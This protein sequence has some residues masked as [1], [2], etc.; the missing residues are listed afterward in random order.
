M[1]RV[2]RLTRP[3]PLQAHVRV[4]GERN[5]ERADRRAGSAAVARWAD[6]WLLERALRRNEA[7]IA[8]SRSS[9][10]LQVQYRGTRKRTTL[11]PYRGPMPRALWWS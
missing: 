8:A 3:F 11:G 9:H 6:A 7:A 10:V 5:S 4:L 1:C 2:R